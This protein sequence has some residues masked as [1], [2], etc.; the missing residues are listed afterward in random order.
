MKSLMAEPTGK[1]QNGRSELHM[2]MEAKA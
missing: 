1:M 2:L